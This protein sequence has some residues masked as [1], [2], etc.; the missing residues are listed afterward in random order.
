MIETKTARVFFYFL[1]GFFLLLNLLTLPQY[2]MTWD[3]AAQHHVGKVALSYATGQSDKIEFL[4][5]DLK[6]YGPFFEAANQYFGRAF[7]ES[8]SLGYVDAFHILIVLTA[9]LGL[10]LFFKLTS[11]LFGERIA[12]F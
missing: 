8:F 10:L 7:L 2:G 11:R 4:R 12:R 5:D 1:L 6:Y 3:E 9:A